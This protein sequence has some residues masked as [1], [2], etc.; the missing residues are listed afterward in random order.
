MKTPDSIQR[1]VAAQGE[2]ISRAPCLCSALQ[3]CRARV[4][5]VRLASAAGC[6]TVG[7]GH[8][9]WALTLQHKSLS[10]SGALTDSALHGVKFDKN[11]RRASE[12]MPAF[13]PKRIKRKRFRERTL[14][15]CCWQKAVI[16]FPVQ[17]ITCQNLFILYQ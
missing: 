8:F 1:P 12:K 6:S 16:F 4:F 3:H 14:I 10:R 11:D 15:W 5:L 17:K 9:L 13:L 7:R 2:G